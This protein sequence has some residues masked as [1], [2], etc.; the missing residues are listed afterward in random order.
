MSLTRKARPKSREIHKR[1]KKRPPLRLPMYDGVVFASMIEVAW[2]SFFTHM[3]IRWNYEPELLL[4]PSFGPYPPD[5]Y[6]PEFDCYVECKGRLLSDYD[7][8]KVEE[9]AEFT[10]KTFVLAR[11][12]PFYAIYRESETQGLSLIV[13]GARGAKTYPAH[14]GRSKEGV[15]AFYHPSHT[16]FPLVASHKWEP[17]NRPK[18]RRDRI[19]R[20]AVRVENLKDKVHV[21]SAD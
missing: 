9:A 11:G 20:S 12:T 14:V 7:R 21:P 8:Q 5:F 13:P 3:G 2:A 10:G 15:I 18:F 19:I 4:L 6:L 16:G 1:K 17:G